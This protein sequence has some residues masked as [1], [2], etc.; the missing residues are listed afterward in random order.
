[1]L[2]YSDNSIKSFVL[3]TYAILAVLALYFQFSLSTVLLIELSE[4]LQ[5]LPCENLNDQLN[6]FFNPL[7]ETT[8]NKTFKKFN[9]PSKK[10]LRIKRVNIKILTWFYL[11]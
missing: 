2:Y 3:P 4:Y 11:L 6:N 10:G 5:I 1:M 8:L 7:M 9:P